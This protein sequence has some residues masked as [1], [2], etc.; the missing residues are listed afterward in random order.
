MS[1]QDAP[2]RR[3]FIVVGAGLAGMRACTTLRRKGFTG[4]LVLIGGEPHLPYDRPPLSKDVLRGKKDS[5]ALPFDPAKLDL[6]VRLN[7]RATG[8]DAAA[9]QLT[10][11]GPDGESTESFD[12]LVIATGATPIRLPGDGE[13]LVLRTIEDALVL[14]DRLVDGARVVIIG[15]SWIGAEVATVARE[16]G[17]RVTCLEAGPAPLAQALGSEIAD[18]L[19]GWW[20]GIDLRVDTAVSRIDPSD[21]DRGA[22]V[23][24]ADG[25]VLAADVVVT[26]VGV[27]PDT[28]WLEGS[29]LTLQRGVVV[30]DRLI[31]APGIVALGDI[32]SRDSARAGGRLSL[33]HWDEASTAGMLMAEALLDPENAAVYDPVPYFWS[34]Q[35][36][37]KLQYVGH[38]GPADR[39][40]IDEVDGEL[41]AVRWFNAED[42]LTA[43]LGVDLPKDLVKH[44]KAVGGPLQQPVA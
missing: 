27:R 18:R 34:D 38:R 39:I 16:H 25:T 11:R 17:C 35:F 40:E 31:A 6:E 4:R 43:W 22:Q 37:H 1:D 36:G 23:L 19:R 21:S 3:T 41:S 2:D 13:Q 14:R 8:L 9:R 29:G 30:D 24:L 26:G 42:N 5:T 12:A 28:G 20:D 7:T 10:T 15:G 32:A 44:R 33:E